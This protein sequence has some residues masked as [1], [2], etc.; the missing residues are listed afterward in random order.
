MQ[1]KSFGTLFII[2][3]LINTCGK[4]NLEY[5]GGQYSPSP[6]NPQVYC[7]DAS[8]C[9]KII[10]G[11]LHA[12][13]NTYLSAGTL[14]TTIHETGYIAYDAHIETNFRKANAFDGAVFD[15]IPQFDLKLSYDFNG[16]IK[17]DPAHLKTS[18]YSDSTKDKTFTEGELEFSKDSTVLNSHKAL[19]FKFKDY[20]PAK[21]PIIGPSSTDKSMHGIL[22]ISTSRMDIISIEGAQIDGLVYGRRVN[23]VLKK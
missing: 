14:K 9:A 19:G 15:Y 18:F 20:N 10:R 16:V 8:D 6:H 4:N 3:T 17:V 12:E 1:L 5:R 23:L 13:P 7:A 21:E 2:V 11:E 22:Y